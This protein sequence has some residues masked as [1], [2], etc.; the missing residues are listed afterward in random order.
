MNKKERHF[1]IKQIISQEVITNQTELIKKLN[2]KKVDVTQAT[3]SRDIKELKITKINDSSGVIKYGVVAKEESN[4]SK[5]REVFNDYVSSIVQV[6]VLN[7]LKTSLGEANIVAAE[8]D[9][10]QVPEIVG[11]IAGTDTLVLFSGSE[12]E[13]EKLNNQLLS[14]LK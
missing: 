2:E 6:Q 3:I 1:L 5:L 9:E 12:I 14:Y 8:L 11:T 7:V 10:M 4:D 13:A